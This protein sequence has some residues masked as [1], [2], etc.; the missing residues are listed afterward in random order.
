MTYT[1][2]GEESEEIK[3]II[4]V[5]TYNNI[6][7]GL[8]E[9]EKQIVSLKILSNFTFKKIGQMLSMPTPTVQW[10]YY[11]AVDSLKI[12]IGNLALFLCT[13]I[14][15]IIKNM[16]NE[17]NRLNYSNKSTD[18]DTSESTSETAINKSDSTKM[19]NIEEIV[20][21][22]RDKEIS[23]ATG[24][25]MEDEYT[26]IFDSASNYVLTGFCGVF[27]IISIIFAI[28][29]KNYQQKRKKKTSK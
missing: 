1:K 17:R 10:K 3:K 18:M 7:S 25:N 6:I 24:K 23:S 14:V 29:F 28:F 13:F 19:T 16:R 9:D 12:S 5:D 2:C 8:N 4:D 27:L 15:L 26:N 22:Y 21:P 20:E 11:K